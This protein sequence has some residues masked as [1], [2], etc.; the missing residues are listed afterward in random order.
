M[1]TRCFHFLA[2]RR[3]ASEILW[4]WFSV[5]IDAFVKHGQLPSTGSFCKCP[6]CLR[7]Q[8]PGTQSCSPRW[9]AGTRLFGSSRL[10]PKVCTAGS[11]S[12]EVETGH[13]SR[14]SDVA[15]KLLNQHR[16]G[17]AKSPS[18]NDFVFTIFIRDLPFLSLKQA[19]LAP[20]GTFAPVAASIWKTLHLDFSKWFTP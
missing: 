19:K 1:D 7:S 3:G 11:W 2:S 14:H 6:R 12:Q 10:P 8:D 18:Q 5:D 16:H 20:L 13:R 9:A 4:T 17:W 15:P